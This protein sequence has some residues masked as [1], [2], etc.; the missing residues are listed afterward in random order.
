MEARRLAHLVPSGVDLIDAER[1][2]R[3]LAADLAFSAY[4]EFFYENHLKAHW[5]RADYPRAMLLND[6]VMPSFGC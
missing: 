1:E 4:V 6:A 2:R 5:K 3:Q